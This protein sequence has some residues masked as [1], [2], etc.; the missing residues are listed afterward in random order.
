[1][2]VRQRRL[3]A[4]YDKICTFF[5]GRSRIRVLKTVGTPPEK[6][7]LEFLVTS[8]QRDLATQKLRRHKNFIVEMVLTGAYPRLPPQCKM[9]TPVFHPNI[10][11]HAICI[12]DHWAA[13]ES[14]PNLIVRIGE[15]LSFQSY[16]VKSPLN[17]E[18]AKWVEKNEH[19]LPVD[20]FDF[21]SLLTVGEAVGRNED[22]SFKAGNE[23]AN[24]GA[25]RE[26]SEMQVCISG[27]VTCEGCS[28][29]CPSCESLVCLKCSLSACAI[30]NQTV[31]HKCIHKCSAC[32]R[33]SC[34]K[35]TARCSICNQG[36]C[37]DCLIRCARCAK[38]ACM[39]HIH[40]A[41]VGGKR[42]FLCT[43][44]NPSQ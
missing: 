12:G 40:K 7:Q 30:C 10:A 31:C 22:G 6:Y 32:K 29:V 14:L 34:K 38:V 20:N 43:S 3:K 16:N 35:H 26:A 11:P 4:D 1:M 25:T 19:R 8:L 21:S 33:L 24:C 13:G 15:M 37:H 39:D 42:S 18:A 9:L 44:C 41:E 17:G 2:S 27:H 5:S 36:C 23:C 28:H